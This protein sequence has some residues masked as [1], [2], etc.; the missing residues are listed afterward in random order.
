VGFLRRRDGRVVSPWVVRLAAAALL[1][2]AFGY[3]PLH[4]YKRSGFEKYL[5]LRSDLDR[6]NGKNEVL[7]AQVESLSRDVLLLRDDP[8][9]VEQVARHE[10]GWV[11]PGE[12][13]VDWSSGSTDPK[14]SGLEQRASAATASPGAG[15]V[16]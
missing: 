4:L 8:R 3:T 15:S 16:R 1:T 12:I 14:G 11:K 9:I 5:Q 13:V 2:A 10:V 6:L 7:A